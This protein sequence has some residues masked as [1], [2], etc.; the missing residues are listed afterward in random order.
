MRQQIR[1]YSQVAVKSVI[2][3]SEAASLYLFVHCEEG[4]KIPF[5]A[6]IGIFVFIYECTSSSVQKFNVKDFP[7]NLKDVIIQF[8]RSRI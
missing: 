8:C 1:Q 3:S 4:L 5:A 6:E 2:V 7:K